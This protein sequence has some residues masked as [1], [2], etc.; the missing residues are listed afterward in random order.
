MKKKNIP[1]DVI[2]ALHEEGL[3]DREIAE[4]CGC[5]RS[6]ITIRLNKAGYTQ[7]KSKIDDIELRNR[8]SKSL[9]GRYTGDNNQNFKGYTTEKIVARGIFK[10][11]SKRMIR[12]SDYTCQICGHR[13]G[14]LETHHIKPF[15]VIM[16]EFLSDEYNGNI[17]NLYEQLTSY[18]PFMDEDNLMVLCEDCH[19]R[20]HN[21]DNHEPS[22]FN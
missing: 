21:K 18:Q 6:N 13:G 11:I 20:I 1:L 14:N 17:S 10:T 3:Y 22:S 19:K 4:I 5:E 9:L 12:N 15:S 8:I 2:V 7:R 16:Q